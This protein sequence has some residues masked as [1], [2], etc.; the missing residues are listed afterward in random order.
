MTHIFSTRSLSR[1]FLPFNNDYSSFVGQFI[2]TRRSADV[3]E[4]WEENRIGTWILAT[5]RLPVRNICDERGARVGLCVGFP[6]GASAPW[7]GIDDFYMRTAGRWLLILGDIIYLDPYGSLS[8]VY[9]DDAIASSA[10][11]LNGEA[12][13]DSDNILALGFP[14]TDAWFPFG[15]T[16][17]L[18]VRRLLPNHCLNLTSWQVK[19]HW[20][21]ANTDLS[22]DRDPE[23]RVVSIIASLRKTINEVAYPVTLSLTAGR[24]SRMVLACSRERVESADFFTFDYGSASVDVEV[25]RQL[26]TQFHLRHRLLPIV[27][28]THKELTAWMYRTGHSVSGPIW[29]IHKTLNQ[30]NSKTV[31]LPGMAGEVGR[32][33][34]WRDRDKAE[35][36]LRADD[37][38]LRCKL[39]RNERL[40]AEATDY[41]DGLKE[42]DTFVKLDLL[43]AEQRLG[44]WASPSYLGNTRSLFEFTPFNQRSVLIDMMRLP[45][46]YRLR[47]RLAHDVCRIAWPGLE[48]LPFNEA[49]GFRWLP[50]KLK[51][52]AKKVVKS[53]FNM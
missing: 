13:W 10:T 31:L 32:A 40:R 34:Y 30:Y 15:L 23:S 16:A 47:Q 27:A 21:L 35:R 48:R 11:L 8:A 2:L 33:Y 3:P 9:S 42:F 36:E 53:I 1:F 12:R 37:I 52:R 6:Q 29:K 14:E 22:R 7:N 45:A 51:I 38:L 39:P 44:C 20:P 49:P 46:D 5:L 24:D 41:L 4:G 28:A 18:D 50:H 25:A 43:Y 26:A 19:R 17:R